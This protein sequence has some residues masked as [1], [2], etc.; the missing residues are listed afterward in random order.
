VTDARRKRVLMVLAAASVVLIWRIVAVVN[1][2]A[3]VEATAA[4]A[5]P[6]PTQPIA[7]P[8]DT[9]RIP[10]MSPEETRAVTIALASVME[11]PWG[12]DPFSMQAAGKKA[13]SAIRTKA[14]PSSAAPAPAFVLRAVSRR[15]RRWCA[16]FAGKIV[17]VGD[18]VADEF[19]V[20]GIDQHSLTLLRGGWSYRYEIG[21]E[22]PVIE[23]FGEGRAP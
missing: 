14:P 21:V 5:P 15:D 6:A 4:S 17:G 2:Y 13:D 8:S 18:T 3:P 22:T 9:A 10:T 7:P 1:K 16:I 19:Q 12:R 11:Q 23:Q 20:I